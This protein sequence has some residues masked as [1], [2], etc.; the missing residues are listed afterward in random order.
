MTKI[1][2]SPYLWWAAAIGAAIV[3]GAG[4]AVHSA[5]RWWRSRRG[6]RS[7]WGR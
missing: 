4:W 6:G 5:W 2:T 1:L 7:T 3:M